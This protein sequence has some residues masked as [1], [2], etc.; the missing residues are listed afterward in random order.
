MNHRDAGP[1]KCSTEL[2]HLND[3][4]EQQTEA[5][6]TALLLLV[7]ALVARCSSLPLPAEDTRLLAE[8]RAHETRL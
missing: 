4:L 3:W 5:T 2:L 6:M 1:Y 7:A 8:V